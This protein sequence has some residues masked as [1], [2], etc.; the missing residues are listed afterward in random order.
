MLTLYRNHYSHRH[1]RLYFNNIIIILKL[2]QT[3]IATNIP[4]LTPIIPFY[5]QN[6]CYNYHHH[7]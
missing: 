6:Y 5:Y 4:L 7:Y 1:Y 3:V 2:Y